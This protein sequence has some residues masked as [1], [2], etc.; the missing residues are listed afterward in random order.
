[1]LPQR[2]NDFLIHFMFCLFG[3]FIPQENQLRVDLNAFD[4]FLRK[5]C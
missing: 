3:Y 2:E 1:M 5:D 4:G